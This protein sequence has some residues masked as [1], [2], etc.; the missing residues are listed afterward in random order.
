MSFPE[1]K[2]IGKPSAEEDAVLDYFLTTDSVRQ[3][4]QNEIFL[5]LGRKGAEKLPLF[6]TSLRTKQ[7]PIIEL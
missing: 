3:I 1:I 4:E 7:T 2:S 6:V 5:I